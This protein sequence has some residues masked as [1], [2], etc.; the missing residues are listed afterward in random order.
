MT[1]IKLWTGC[2]VASLLAVAGPTAEPQAPAKKPNSLLTGKLVAV[3]AMPGNLDKWISDDLRAW[4][5]YKV[6]G[7]PEGA[8]L[9]IEAHVPEK[10][11]E[12][13]MPPGMP[14]PGRRSGRVRVPGT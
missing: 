9:V 8:S 4:G 7:D 6:T 14:Q 11:A 1:R 13:R 3:A 10:P 2:I 12:Y 5:K